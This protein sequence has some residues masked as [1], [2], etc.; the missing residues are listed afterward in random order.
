MSNRLPNR[1]L[2]SRHS[3]ETTYRYI[4]NNTPHHAQRRARDTVKRLQLL[5]NRCLHEQSLWKSKRILDVENTRRLLEDLLVHPKQRR[6]QRPSPLELYSER[7]SSN[8]SKLIDAVSNLARQRQEC[9]GTYRLA[10]GLIA[11]MRRSEQSVVRRH[12]VMGVERL[13]WRLRRT[14]DRD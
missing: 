11:E 9:A 6:I 12:P 14:S 1:L 2:M 8:Q 3:K 4:E 13:G 10:S 5:E 7:S